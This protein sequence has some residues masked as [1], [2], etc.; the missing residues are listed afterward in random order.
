M[1]Q[2]LRPIRLG[3]SKIRNKLQPLLILGVP[4]RHEV[5]P[6]AWGALQRYVADTYGA[7][8]VLNV[9][10]TPDD[11]ARPQWLGNWPDCTDDALAVLAPHV[12]PVFINLD[13]WEEVA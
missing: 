6:Q 11:T 4:V 3:H 8:V 12:K 7:G 10:G 2:V 5:H 9:G 1:I 13:W